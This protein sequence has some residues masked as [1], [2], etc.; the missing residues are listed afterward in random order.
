MKLSWKSPSE[1][2]DWTLTIKNDDGFEGDMT[3]KRE[4]AQ[5]SKFEN[6][7]GMTLTELNRQAIIQALGATIQ[8]TPF[9]SLDGPTR[10]A[11]L[12]LSLTMAIDRDSKKASPITNL[13]CDVENLLTQTLL[14]RTRT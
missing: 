9:K 5:E 8:D 10:N 14:E 12:R 13:D 3:W 1:D 2:E 11:V 7:T 6:N 4:N